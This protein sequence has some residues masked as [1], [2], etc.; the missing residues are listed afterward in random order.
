[1][2]KAGVRSGVLAVAIAVTAT[3]SV[4]M[5]SP[6]IAQQ[7]ADAA[8]NKHA[9]LGTVTAGLGGVVVVEKWTPINVQVIGGEKA[10]NGLI[11][12]T[13]TQDGTQ[14]I[15]VQRAFAT[16]PGRTI[17]VPM[18]AALPPGASVEVKLIV[19][20]QRPESVTIEDPMAFGRGG[21][22]ERIAMREVVHGDRPV[23]GLVAARNG[24]APDLSAIPTFFRQAAAA[25]T[26]NSNSTDR[27][28]VIARIRGDELPTT[29]PALEG[30]SVL[31]VRAE[32][33]RQ[34]DPR[35]V[36]AVRQWLL[37]G[38][39]LVL[40]ASDPGP[41]WRAWLLPGL[42]GE[43]ITLD[44]STGKDMP[45]PA[46]LA[47]WLGTGGDR[48]VKPAKTLSYRSMKL[49]DVGRREG[50]QVGAPTSAG[51]AGPWLYAHGPVGFGFVRILGVDP[52]RLPAT[53]NDDTTPR[54]WLKM[55]DGEPWA[56][57]VSGVAAPS[58]P[59]YNY[60]GSSSGHSEAVRGSIAYGI[61]AL[62]NVPPIQESVFW[63]LGAS[64]LVL[65]LLLGPIDLIVLGRLKLRHRSFI[66]AL[67]WIGI[68]CVGAW[69]M[70]GMV[71]TAKS[72]AT[73]VEVIDVLQG[74]RG[75]GS[76]AF[77]SALNHVFSADGGS[78][79]LQGFEPG[80]L[81]RGVS[82]TSTGFGRRESFSMPQVVMQQT[83]R[84]LGVPEDDGAEAEASIESADITPAELSLRRWTL[85]CFADQGRVKAPLIATPVAQSAEPQIVLQG[86]PAG[87][88]VQ[89]PSAIWTKAG[90]MELDGEIQTDGTVTLRPSFGSSGW[91]A[92]RPTR[93]PS[94]ED[95]LAKRDPYQRGFRNSAEGAGILHPGEMTSLS[96]AD[97]RGDAM[98]VRVQ[99]GQWCV[100]HVQIKNL[101]H[102][103][104]IGPD[105]PLDREA[106]VRVLMP[107]PQAWIGGPAD[108]DRSIKPEPDRTPVLPK[109]RKERP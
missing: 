17:I 77:C 80:T 108:D 74:P 9:R 60:A 96:G 53:V 58:N 99:T 73:R 25:S 107:L 55:L 91:R 104:N 23:I 29:A 44:E 45:M 85:R 86:L 72:S 68:A 27:T 79:G 98:A 89:G 54:A 32:A 47:S 31:V 22:S 13:Y 8:E 39:R 94:A 36:R 97:A 10:E 62:T 48:K 83:S 30:L 103:V 65:A 24:E 50:W 14:A 19:P 2:A 76:L 66:S 38:G 16:T 52:I 64:I 57:D 12:M 18:L 93:W 105:R 51:D 81:V 7:P 41:D 40:I 90:W 75:V 15:E 5:P 106:V 95:S 67:V 84:A 42:T 1:M 46:A 4:L 82:T 59:Y 100:L 28:P 92:D 49:T 101:P 102:T 78:G 34:L 6:A 21:N 71:R 63:I 70:P 109:L 3:A 33:I 88:T 69:M 11:T 26:A 61:D 20:G 56:R 87:A 35:Q 43:V 37:A